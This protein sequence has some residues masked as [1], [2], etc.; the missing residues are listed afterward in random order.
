MPKPQIP[1]PTT[2]KECLLSHTQPSIMPPV[3]III[4]IHYHTVEGTDLSCEKES[5]N[6]QSLLGES[7]TCR[8]IT[9]LILVTKTPTRQEQMFTKQTANTH[10]QHNIQSI[11]ANSCRLQSSKFT[12]MLKHTYPC[13]CHLQKLL[14]CWSCGQVG[15]NASCSF[16]G[17]DCMVWRGMPAGAWFQMQL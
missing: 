14:N 11:T 10:L 7:F 6:T 1:P 9:S 2:I 5:Y 4:K 12:S 16:C 8:S 17:S 3:S 15:M 13:Q